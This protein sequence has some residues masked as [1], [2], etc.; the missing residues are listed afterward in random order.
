MAEDQLL[1]EIDPKKRNDAY[2]GMALGY[3]RGNSLVWHNQAVLSA[4]KI[5]D[6]EKRFQTLYHI[7]TTLED[8]IGADTFARRLEY[9][10]LEC[11]PAAAAPFHKVQIA[12]AL[13]DLAE[14]E[15][16]ERLLLEV[17]QQCDPRDS[18]ML[19]LVGKIRDSLH[20]GK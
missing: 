20:Y 16:A 11:L 15:R 13:A 10:M 6:P 4:K 5:T 7:A 9:L 12:Q 2:L 8:N 17:E 18:N 14:I 3:L 1:H 19:I